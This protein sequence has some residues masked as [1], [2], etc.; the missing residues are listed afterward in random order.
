MKRLIFI[1]FTFFL[2][3]P[4][5]GELPTDEAIERIYRDNPYA[6]YEM[7]RFGYAV[8]RSKVVFNLPERNIIILKN[9]DLRIEYIGEGNLMVG[10]PPYHITYT[11]KLKPH[12][13]V[14]F[15]P[16]NKISP[17][18]YIL[19]GVGIFVGGLVSGILIIK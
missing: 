13:E 1:L 14:G 17:V 11:F 8:T 15:R 5:F 16:E 4:V 6:I 10:E 2:I 19:G 3:S 9:G 7:I 12:V 18:W